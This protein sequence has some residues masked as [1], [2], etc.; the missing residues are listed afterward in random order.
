MPAR[1]VCRGEPFLWL[2]SLGLAKKVTRLQAE[3]LD[4]EVDLDL[5]L[6][7]DLERAATLE[8]SAGG[9]QA[10]SNAFA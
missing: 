2:L 9:R 10:R 5:D 6:D 8:T 7:L 4:L 3:A 1:E